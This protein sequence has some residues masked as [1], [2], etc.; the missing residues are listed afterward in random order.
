MKEIIALDEKIV[1]LPEGSLPEEGI[2][3]SRDERAAAV[4]T[5]PEDIRA[6]IDALQ[7]ALNGVIPEPFDYFVFLGGDEEAS[8]SIN[9]DQM[10][11]AGS[12][13]G[14][15]DAGRSIVEQVRELDWEEQ[16]RLAT[17]QRVQ[18]KEIVYMLDR[19][20]GPLPSA[21]KWQREF[22]EEI[23]DFVREKR[24]DAGK[25]HVLVWDEEEELME[26]E[27]ADGEAF[28]AGLPG[29]IMEGGELLAVVAFGKPLPVERL[30]ALKAEAQRTLQARMRAD[31][32]AKATEEAG[33]ADMADAPVRDVREIEAEVISDSGV[34]PRAGEAAAG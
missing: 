34:E 33:A 6:E 9:L 25:I 26:S 10:P 18:M 8:F 11:A 30:D 4:E 2:D 13:G 23:K 24:R 29:V 5:L 22:R 32:A 19:L 3:I 21:R 16:R 15:F 7:S 31:A 14:D 17:E 27:Y 20:A 1:A 12:I 28:R